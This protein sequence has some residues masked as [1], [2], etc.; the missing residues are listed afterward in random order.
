MTLPVLVA[1]AG[2]SLLPASQEP[3][4]AA[5]QLQADRLPRAIAN[6][7]RA[8]AGRRVGDTLFLR[9]AVRRVVWHLDGD[10]EPGIALL[11]F[12][13]VGRAPQIPG[14]L[15][16]AAAGTVIDVTVQ[17]P[18]PRDTL[19]VRGLSAPG[20]AD[21][22][23]VVPGATAT[24]RFVA[25]REGTYLYWGTT[26]H[27]P[28]R[29]RFGEDSNL[30]AAFIVDPPGAAGPTGE[31]VFV[32][33][34]H[35]FHPSEVPGIKAPN[36]TAVNGK[37]WPHTERLT[38]ALGDSIRWRV[39]N[40]SS[41][42]HPMHLHGAY[43]RVD[44]KGGA[45]ADTVYPAERRRMVATERLLP[46]ETMR[47]AWSPER[48]GGW[49]FHCH[50]VRH[51]APHPPLPGATTP[52]AHHGDPDQHTFH[53]MSGLVLAVY[54]PPPPR[55]APPS[56]IDRRRVRLLVQ[57][58]SV[59]GDAT[60]RFAY[61]LQ[62]GSRPPA[63]DSVPLPGPTLVLTR[64]E[65]TVIEVVNR[66]P[67]HTSVHWHGIELES[68]HDGV[69]G[70]SGFSNRT[71]PAIRPGTSF[72]ARI[73]PRRAGSFMYH[74]HFNELRQYVGGLTGALIVLEPGDRWDP[75]RDRVFLIGDPRGAGPKNTVNGSEAPVFAD[76]RVGTT[77]RFRFMNIA[78]GRPGTR[79][80]LLSEGRPLTWRAI[81]KDGWTLDS[82]QAT[83]RPSVHHVGSGE[84][85]D[86]QFTPNQPGDLLLELRAPNGF[87]FFAAPMSV[88]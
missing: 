68:F 33:T 40:V 28:L 2:L 74:T 37:S 42:P 44:A 87:L 59:A 9:L 76:L 57:S 72:E 14:P 64:G 49:L 29:E 35:G 38:Y 69:V 25:S 82:V 48:P 11:A 31:R 23:V 43:F 16:R 85:A 18:L 3:V 84:T 81:A 26:T 86:F 8:P 36:W 50:V 80:S 13:E 22:L 65:P 19:V 27:A 1:F 88:K 77:Y 61:V 12:A 10:G 56:V 54:I 60:R 6:D 55:Y 83:I 41:S 71:T 67:E 15:L 63:A 70:V 58:D 62:D 17:N 39:I 75:D 21:S 5:V 30:S 51:V 34:E 45:A 20:I 79:V 24:T 52:A 66:T 78:V 47:I 7:N 53:G 32:L 46:G 73:T 4:S